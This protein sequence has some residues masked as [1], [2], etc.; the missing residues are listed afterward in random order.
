MLQRLAGDLSDGRS[1][2][3]SLRCLVNTELKSGVAAFSRRDDE[4]DQISGPALC[5]CA[6]SS[7]SSSL[8]LKEFDLCAGCESE[9]VVL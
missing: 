3:L 7:W 5:L 1:S 8:Q 2:V 4:S 6:G 9:S